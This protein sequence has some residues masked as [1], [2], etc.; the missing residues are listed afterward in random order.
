MVKQKY[1]ERKSPGHHVDLDCVFH[2]SPSLTSSQSSDCIICYQMST[3]EPLRPKETLQCLACD[4]LLS[5]P[6]RPN[7]LHSHPSFTGTSPSFFAF[8]K[9]NTHTQSV[10]ILKLLSCMVE[11]SR[12]PKRQYVAYNFIKVIGS[13]YV[14]EG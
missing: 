6:G 11:T 13:F 10:F 8:G 5:P 12:R 9:K 7:Y 2:E 3:P 4:F 1:G 14:E